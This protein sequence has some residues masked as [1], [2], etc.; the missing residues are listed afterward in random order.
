[1]VHALLTHYGISY[2]HDGERANFLCPFH[3]ENTPSC[4][5]SFEK[6]LWYCFGCGKGGNFYRFIVLMERDED[7]AMRV[8]R[9]LMS[10]V[11]MSALPQGAPGERKDEDGE[12]FDFVAA[13]SRYTKI[14]WALIS[15]THDAY[16]YF[17]RRR[18]L[19]P[20]TLSA[21]DARLTRSDD[22]YPVAI[23]IMRD[24]EMMGYV[25]RYVGDDPKRKRYLYNR[26]LNGKEAMAYHNF[27]NGPLLVVEGM[28]DYLK[29][30][31]FGARAV[32]AILSWRIKQAQVDWLKGQGIDEVVCALDDDEVGRDGCRLLAEHFEVRRFKYPGPPAKDIADL[33]QNEFWMGYESA[34][35]MMK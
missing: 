19:S 5:M 9:R 23:P 1:M 22:G 11:G 29:A 31:Q 7:E 6:G 20:Y 24:G 3:S 12:P 14:D 30:A 21:F 26:G 25:K 27:G 34:E 35:V 32:A 33:N 10:G 8:N 28:L 2:E 18:G 4:G 16:R 13:F 15:R 17:V